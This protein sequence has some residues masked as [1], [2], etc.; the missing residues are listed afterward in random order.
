MQFIKCILC[1]MVAA[2]VLSAVS[3]SLSG[4]VREWRMDQ[5]IKQ[6]ELKVLEE[7]IKMIEKNEEE[8]ER[9]SYLLKQFPNETESDFDILNGEL[10]DL[11][12]RLKYEG[13]YKQQRQPEKNFAST[14]FKLDPVIEAMFR[15]EFALL[16]P[17]KTQEQTEPQQQPKRQIRF[18]RDVVNLGSPRL[19][20]QNLLFRP[21]AKNEQAEKIIEQKEERQ[22]QPENQ[23]E[24]VIPDIV[25]TPRRQ[26]QPKDTP[27]D[28]VK[29][30][31]EKFYSNDKEYFHQKRY[32]K[33]AELNKIQLANNL[34]DK[35]IVAE[36]IAK[37]YALGANARKTL[38][39][40]RTRAMYLRIR[41]LKR[42]RYLLDAYF[43]I[44]ELLAIR[45][46]S[47]GVPATKL[48]KLEKDIWSRLD[49][50]L[51]E[52]AVD[53]LLQMTQGK[54]AD[55]RLLFEYVDSR[56]TPEEMKTYDTLCERNIYRIKYEVL[57]DYIDEY[58]D[59]LKRTKTY[60]RPQLRNL[61]RDKLLTVYKTF[62]HDDRTRS[63]LMEEMRTN[64]ARYMMQRDKLL[65]PE[66]V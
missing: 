6:R 49:A 51:S 21:K 42:K 56:T 58:G 32:N 22:Q 53:E 14:S 29:A 59:R 54:P 64:K 13:V 11:D 19:W 45:R 12:K 10:R 4:A 18:K 28:E 35:I 43:G 23:L 61:D 60:T 57:A 46:R 52:H 3:A 65:Y 20:L 44:A 55:V 26:P 66:E 15:E 47:P 41:Q 36:N 24:A 48:I 27:S 17:P 31:I 38:E 50:V 25:P 30:V 2:S 62:G 7:K 16:E 34:I 37:Y 39:V 5:F 33:D 40:L 1:S 9:L 63:Q 8:E